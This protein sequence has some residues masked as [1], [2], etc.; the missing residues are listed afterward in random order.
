MKSLIII[1]HKNGVLHRM[2]REAISGA[3]KI[4]GDITALVIGE[5]AELI[6]SELSNFQIEKTFMVNHELVPSYNA[7]GYK[8]II[9]Q[10]IESVSPNVIITGHT[11]QA[12]DF[13]PRISAS[14]DIP[15]IPD[16]IE[17]EDN[18]YI[19]QVLNSKLNAS[20]SSSE[21]Q[22]LVSFQSASFSE[23]DIVKGSSSSEFFEASLD[24][25]SIKSKSDEPFQESASEVDLESAELIVSVGRGIE[26]E[27]NKS[28]AFE[29]A[30]VIGA[31]VS[32]SRPVVD[33]GWLPSSRQVGSS[34]STVSPKLYLSLGVSGAIQHV[35]GM[36][37]SKN[38][39]A[40]NK[41]PGA[42][43]FEIADYAVVGDLL[44]IVPKLIT[45]LKDS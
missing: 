25:S 18:I 44:E 12:R 37:G 10:V 29:L 6:S 19:K 21:E 27:E 34:G 43:I 41:D 35:V 14:L 13:M 30:E 7:D 20:I 17:I 16:V 9:K 1:E 39:L 42:P 31:E 33:A 45:A 8:E 15:F 32:A 5:N 24:A 36:K 11:Y 22:I 28:I 3:Q 2:S 4:G 38:I 26:K 23:E 40:I